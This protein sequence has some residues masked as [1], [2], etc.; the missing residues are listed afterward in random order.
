[1]PDFPVDTIEV[2]YFT[3]KWGPYNFDLTDALPTGVT[4]ESISV[5]SFLGKLD[6]GDS[7]DPEDVEE[8]TSDIIETSL[9]S[10]HANTTLNIFFKFPTGKPDYYSLIGVTH[11][12]VFEVTLNTTGTYP[13]YFHQVIVYE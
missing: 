6:K 3:S 4:I 8:T 13:F 9:C 7:L 12:L 2:R 11:T 10:V 1:M 5:R